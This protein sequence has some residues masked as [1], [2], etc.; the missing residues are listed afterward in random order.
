MAARNVQGLSRITK[1]KLRWVLFIVFVALFVLSLVLLSISLSRGDEYSKTVLNSSYY[2]SKII[3]FRRGTITDINGETLAVSEKVYYVI[4]DC[5]ILNTIEDKEK[6]EKSIDKTIAA[7][8]QC[9]GDQGVS[10]EQLREYIV[11]EPDN[12]YIR[13]LANQEYEKIL[14]FLDLQEEDEKDKDG[15]FITG[16]WFEESYKRMYPLG[17]LVSHVVGYTLNSE[18]GQAG[19]EA[20]Y[21]EELTGI[22]GRTYG[23]RNSDSYKETTTKAA[24]D[25]NNIISTINAGAQRII[26]KHVIAF[27]EAHK[28]EAKDGLGSLDTSVLVMNPNTGAV[29]AMYNYPTYDSNNYRDITVS[30]LYTAEQEASMSEEEIS[31]AR[32]SIWTNYIIGKTYEPGSV[33]KPF[34]VAAGLET[35]K[36]SGNESYY[37]DGGQDFK[38]AGYY[39]KC[40]NEKGHGLLSLSECIS[41]SCN[42]GLM[43]IAAQI[44][45]KDFSRYQSIFGF[46]KKT[47]IDLPGEVNAANLIFSADDMKEIDLATNSFGQT[48]NVTMIQT[49][50]AFCSLINGGRYYKPYLVQKIETASGETV[51]NAKPVLVKET[52]SEE[53]S[54]KLR[55]YMRQ[56]MIT[57]TGKTANIENYEIGAKTGTAEKLPRA[58]QNYLLS[59]M[60]YA[61]NDNPEVLIYVVIDEPN[62][63]KQDNSL[64]VTGLSKAIMEELFPYLEITS[65]NETEQS[66]DNLWDF[67]E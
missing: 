34:T 37:C 8:V 23:Y 48:F 19:L 14:P 56:T 7:L 53:T 18:T 46:G 17:S 52:V 22:N 16:V 44:G 40:N 32:S 3:P 54:E 1:T 26:E 39:V 10:Q 47:N 15:P 21:D 45:I 24:T 28:N 66:N 41:M 64:L 33:A 6:K 36:L 43:Q 50:S 58:D 12:A 38:E 5:K 59:F 31:N 57:G 9:F 65:T 20:Q 42:D 30:G 62:V 61:P 55:S 63:E 29:I 60:G 11:N 49:A 67:A 51:F 35:G 25:G 27:N 4:L 2:E 13:L